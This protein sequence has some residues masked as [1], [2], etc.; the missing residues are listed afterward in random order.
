MGLACISDVFR[1][2]SIRG[3]SIPTLYSGFPTQESGGNIVLQ[4]Q[5]QEG[6]K[7]NECVSEHPQRTDKVEKPSFQ[8]YALQD[9]QEKMCE[10]DPMGYRKGMSFPKSF[11]V[12]HS[13]FQLQDFR[14]LRSYF[15]ASESQTVRMIKTLVQKYRRFFNHI[16]SSMNIICTRIFLEKDVFDHNVQ[17][18]KFVLDQNISLH[19]SGVPQPPIPHIIDQRFLYCVECFM[20]RLKGVAVEIG[21]WRE[22]D[23]CVGSF[24]VGPIAKSLST[25]FFVRHQVQEAADSSRANTEG[26]LPAASP[27]F[28]QVN[29]VC[30][31]RRK[32]PENGAM[33]RQPVHGDRNR[34]PA[35]TSRQTGDEHT[36]LSAQL[37]PMKRQRISLFST[38]DTY[39]HED[40]RRIEHVDSTGA[41]NQRAE[42]A[43]GSS[44]DIPL[45]DEVSSALVDIDEQILHETFQMISSDSPG[46]YR[47]AK[48]IEVNTPLDDVMGKTESG[49]EKELYTPR[50]TNNANTSSLLGNQA[51]KVES[52]GK[53]MEYEV[54]K[55]ER[56]QVRNGEYKIK[57]RSNTLA[58]QDSNPCSPEICSTSNIP[59]KGS[60]GEA[61]TLST[62]SMMKLA[63]DPFKIAQYDCKIAK[64]QYAELRCKV[65]KEFG[66]PVIFCSL[67][68][69]NIV[70]PN[71]VLHIH[72]GFPDDGRLTY[73]FERPAMGWVGF[74][75]EI[76]DKFQKKMSNLG[77][78]VGIADVLK[79]WAK[80]VS[81]VL[82]K[83]SRK[84]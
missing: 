68:R 32:P 4:S 24:G 76:H 34:P 75:Q 22:N 8:A 29:T 80:T 53:S 2:S 83:N 82:D 26:L 50:T 7:T 11:E 55:T 36:G 20:K 44:F 14:V 67:H 18:C 73:S 30:G 15:F 79:I 81:R 40:M 71:L 84:T 27:I 56:T 45:G 66:K 70:L 77:K 59:G 57:E 38:N 31:K 16:M 10:T 61:E 19:P 51:R 21:L 78:R 9:C 17:I 23:A 5:N 52:L 39:I 37:P 33:R 35:R 43:I 41:K 72:A 69:E 60:T 28:T 62:I 46:S 63:N 1:D 12:E 74:L 64:K 65:R 48:G 25:D 42:D 6:G 47:A 3:N 49:L 13:A 54:R 58:Q